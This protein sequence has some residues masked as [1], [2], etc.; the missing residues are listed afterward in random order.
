MGANLN[1]VSFKTDDKKAIAQDWATMVTESQYTSGHEYSGE[2][3]MMG[4]DEIN[5]R[6]IT[7]MEDERAAEDYIADNHEKWECAMAVPYK[8]G[9]K[10]HYVLGGWCSS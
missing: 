4:S 6:P 3:G 9:D 7:P 8:D 5:W 10:R 2:I 1:T